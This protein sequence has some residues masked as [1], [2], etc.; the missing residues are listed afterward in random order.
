MILVAKAYFLLCSP[1]Q[2]KKELEVV[3]EV[4][5]HLG[6]AVEVGQ[7]VEMED[8]VLA[9]LHLMTVQ[10]DLVIDMVLQVVYLRQMVEAYSKCY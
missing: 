5:V 9:D 4:D 10:E 3:E 6:V 8:L 1:R 2:A 7:L